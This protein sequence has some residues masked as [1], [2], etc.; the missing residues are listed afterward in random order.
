MSVRKGP[1]PYYETKTCSLYLGVHIAEN[2][3][4]ATF[5]EVVRMPPGHPDFD[6]ICQKNRKINVKAAC[7]NTPG[8]WVFS[9]LKNDRCDDYMLI[10]FDNVEDLNPKHLWFIPGNEINTKNQIKIRESNLHNWAIWEKPLDDVIA[11]CRLFKESQNLLNIQN[12]NSISV[13]PYEFLDLMGN[14]PAIKIINFF[15]ENTPNNYNKTQIAEQLGMSKKTLYDT[16]PVLEKYDILKTIS[17]DGKSRFYVLNKDNK[18]V[19]YLLKLYAAIEA[20]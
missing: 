12:E 5:K 8:T 9:I 15:I 2:V 18:I 13:E 3:L 1:R 19:V 20:D 17:S 6:F 10:A 16:W 14:R 11:E 4:A 7:E